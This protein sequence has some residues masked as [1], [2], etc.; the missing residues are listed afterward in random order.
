VDSSLI[1]FRP[2]RGDKFETADV[3]Q[4]ERTPE[5][6]QQSEEQCVFKNNLNATSNFAFSLTK[7]CNTKWYTV[8]N[9]DTGIELQ[10]S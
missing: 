9:F 8:D 1:Q 5:I 7:T 10:R 4:R 6:H 3:K 2:V